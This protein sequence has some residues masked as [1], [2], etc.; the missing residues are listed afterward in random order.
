MGIRGKAGFPKLSTPTPK[1]HDR[2]VRREAGL[3]GRP[4]KWWEC[5]KCN[6]RF[7][8]FGEMEGHIHR[9]KKSY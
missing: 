1:T 7:D 4:G 8:D 6:K 9:P 3:A 2:W 5:N